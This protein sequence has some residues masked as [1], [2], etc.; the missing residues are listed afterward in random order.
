M[1]SYLLVSL[2]A[3]AAGVFLCHEIRAVTRK[4]L[5]EQKSL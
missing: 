3:P 2:Q 4:F 5:A 1:E